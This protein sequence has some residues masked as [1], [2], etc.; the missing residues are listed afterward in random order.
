MKKL[1]EIIGPSHLKA[2]IN[3]DAVYVKGMLNHDCGADFVKVNQKPPVGLELVAG[4]RYCSLDGDADRIVY[5]YKGQG[6]KLCSTIVR[7]RHF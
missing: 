6:M 1:A 4:E 7:T 5:Y 2:R 3:N